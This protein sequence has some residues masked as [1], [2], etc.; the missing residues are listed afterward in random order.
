VWFNNTDN[1]GCVLWDSRYGQNYWL[2]VTA[3]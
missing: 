2:D 3:A 1:T